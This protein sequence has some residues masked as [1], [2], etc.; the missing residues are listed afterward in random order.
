MEVDVHPTVSVVIPTYNY[1]RFLGQAIDSVLAQT[2]PVKEIIVVD[3]GSTDDT[4]NVLARYGPAV[5]ALKQKNCGPAAARN[6][7]VGIAGG[8]LIAFL[9]ADDFW[10]PDKLAKQVRRLKEGTF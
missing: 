2:C 7:G 8:D 5:R 4:F 1:A 10:M 9:D 3:D 6:R